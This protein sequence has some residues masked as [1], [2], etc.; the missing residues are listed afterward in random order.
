VLGTLN[1]EEPMPPKDF[2]ETIAE[3]GDGSLPNLLSERLAE[4]SQRVDETEGT[5][6]MTLTLKVEKKGDMVMV[7]P[8]LRSARPE[9]AFAAKLFYVG[10]AGELSEKNTRQGTLPIGESRSRTKVVAIDGGKKPKDP[11]DKDGN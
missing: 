7:T 8:E 11:G 4:I 1:T 10:T 6:K 5:G 3:F 9:P 2:F